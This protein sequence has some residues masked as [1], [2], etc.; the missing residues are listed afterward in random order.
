MTDTFVFFFKDKNDVICFYDMKFRSNV[1]RDVLLEIMNITEIDFSLDNDD[2]VIVTDKPSIISQF[3]TSATEIYKQLGINVVFFRKCR[4]YNNDNVIYDKMVENV[5]SVDKYIEIRD[6]C[7]YL[8][9]EDFDIEDT[10]SKPVDIFNSENTANFDNQEKKYYQNLFSKLGRNPTYTE[11]FDLLQSNSEHARHWFFNGN[12]L[13]KDK[14][15]YKRVRDKDGNDTLMKMIKATLFNIDR[16]VVRGNSLIAFKDNSSVIKGEEIVYFTA[17]SKDNYYFISRVVNPVLTAETHNFPTLIAPFHGAHT[18]VGGRIRDNQATGTGALVLSSLAGYCVGDIYKELNGELSGIE[19]KNLYGEYNTPTTILIEASNGASDYGNKF[20]EP[21]IGG[22][23]RSF[24]T[25]NISDV[26][27]NNVDRIEWVKPIMFSAG[28]GAICDKNLVK[29]E[30]QPGMYVVRIGGPAYKIGLGGGYCSSIDQNSD[31]TNS[32]QSAVQ[33]G[34]PEMCTKM[35]NVLRYLID[36][37]NIIESIHDQGSGGLGNVVKEIVYPYGADIYLHNVTLGD[38]TMKGWEIWSAEFQESNVLLVKKVNINK[39]EFICKRENIC[40]DILGEIS[41]GNRIKVDFKG[42]T[43]MDLPLNEIVKPDFKKEYIIEETSYVYS[44]REINNIGISSFYPYLSQILKNVDVG[45][46]RF[47]VNKV[48]RSVTGLVVQQQ[49]VGKF[50][51]PISNYSLTATSYFNK[52]GIVTSI[53]E[54]PILTLLDSHAA[55]TMT[56]GEMLTNMM[57]VYVGNITN[58]KCSGNWM[59]ALTRNGESDKLVKTAMAMTETM[60]FLGLSIDGGKDSLSMG[61][62]ING[63]DIYSPNNLVITGYAHV[64]DYTKRVTP[65]LKSETS[66]LIYIKFTNKNR[67]AGSVFQRELGRISGVPPSLDLSALSDLDKTW[68]IIQYMISKNKID[69]LHDISDGG[70]ITTLTEMSIASDIGINVFIEE[71]EQ[72]VANFLFNEELGVVVEVTQ[73]N[74]HY[75]CKK[76]RE[77]KINFYHIGS[78]KYAKDITIKNKNETFFSAHIDN[79]RE[80]W[81]YTSNKL[82]FKQMAEL[83]A[84]QQKELRHF[85]TPLK[86]KLNKYLNEECSYQPFINFLTDGPNVAVIRCEGSNGHRELA[87]AFSMAQFNVTDIHINSLIETPELLDSFKGIAFPGGFSF[88]DT[89]GAARGWGSMMIYAPE[90]LAAFKRFYSRSDTFSIGICNGCQLM[91]NFNLLNL[92]SNKKSKIRLVENDSKRFE[93]RFSLVKVPKSNSIFFRKMENM[94]FGIWVAHGEGK[95]IN[96][97]RKSNIAL[98]Y[99]INSEPTRL[100]PFNPNGSEFGTAAISSDNGRHLA[101]MPHPERCFLDWQLPYKGTYGNNLKQSPWVFIFRNAYRFVKNQ[102]RKK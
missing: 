15:R 31:N 57:G 68:D 53:G 10:S 26:N 37:N 91:V 76:L 46:K 99:V 45:S 25:L 8:K 80:F 24:S 90:L 39:L 74:V 92:N 78:T 102:N 35:N 72:N 21:I 63:K 2:Y 54:K 56:I 77:S 42:S 22:F 32:D 29:K 81:E 3:S 43:L 23:T 64:H 14:E 20:G 67:I 84:H 98:Q 66:S 1:N 11:Y 101:I 38:N 71:K 82:E 49:C 83:Q 33:R 36:E 34:D 97:N 62:K 96:V 18:G 86:F 9:Q 52:T 44:S 88:S 75:L 89:F 73:P 30:P 58:I 12:Y 5:Y 60:R 13:R 27:G 100:Y 59:W 79:L 95:F 7:D 51:C 70:L 47:L 48:D 93:S 41:T 87:A 19:K 94:E 50:Q 85:A 40:L 65:E 55:A 28:I 69:A 4:V 6:T 16:Y 17:L 61:T